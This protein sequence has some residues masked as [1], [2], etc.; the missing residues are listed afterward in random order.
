[1]TPA[2]QEVFTDR[3][4]GLVSGIPLP[5]SEREELR[6]AVTTEMAADE[7]RSIEQLARNNPAA[8]TR[9]IKFLMRQAR[10]YADQ[11][12]RVTPGASPESVYG[13]IMWNAGAANAAARLA[14]ELFP[15]LLAKRLDRLAKT[16]HNRRVEEYAQREPDESRSGRVEWVPVPG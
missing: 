11:N 4:E 2:Q 14:E 7:V 1:M 6:G 5:E 12:G 9:L 15:S 8:W 10:H 16:S 3:I 13:Q